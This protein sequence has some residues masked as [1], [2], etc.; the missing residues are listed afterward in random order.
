VSTDD[1]QILLLDDH[2]L[3]RESAAKL[4]SSEPGFQVVAHC[5][6]IEDALAALKRQRVDI[7]LLDLDLGERSGVAFIRSARQQGFDG[8][9]L[10]V[11]AGAEP[12]EVEELIRAGIAGIFMKHHSAASLAH[13][14]GDVIAGKVSFDQEFL[15]GAVT[16]TDV[17]HSSAEMARLTQRERQV[18]AG[19]FEGLANKEIARRIGVSESSVK[20]T[21]QQL[22]SKTG[23][24]T[25]SQLVRIAL[26]RRWSER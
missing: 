1:V 23:V 9:I 16:R 7:V 5:G 8:K 19:V 11:T 21:L 3:F 20:A 24:R 14:I 15:Q 10:V 2:A 17:I 26:E 13:A 6:S 18:L 22:F 25:R 4:L 12:H